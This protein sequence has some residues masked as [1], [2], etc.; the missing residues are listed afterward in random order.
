[1]SPLSIL[2]LAFSMSADA[3]AAA[4]G[5]GAQRRPS[6]PVA[7]RAGLVFGAVET[8]TPILGWAL[9]L[10]AAGFVGAVDHWIAFVLLAFVGGKMAVDALG[11]R[12]MADE[13]EAA[14][15]PGGGML[16]LVL[17]AIGTSIDAAAV[18]V[19]LA[20][21][22]A[23]ILLVALAI[24]VATFGMATLGMLLGRAVG[25]RFGRVVEMA[26]GVGLILIGTRILLDHTGWLG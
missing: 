2:I 11:R 3:C 1:M 21:L 14:D 19:T 8:V 24:G 25:A 10:A 6:L 20:F 9:G 4:I 17:T 18:G 12:A 22:G 16:A 7:L 26:G 13:G 23:N 5:R 15:R